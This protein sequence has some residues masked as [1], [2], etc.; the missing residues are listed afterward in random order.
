MREKPKVPFV[1]W[2]GAGHLQESP[3]RFCTV[4]PERV[5]RDVQVFDELMTTIAHLGMV[6]PWS[7]CNVC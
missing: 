1:T 3:L 6:E 5:L 2:Q 7:I 4:F